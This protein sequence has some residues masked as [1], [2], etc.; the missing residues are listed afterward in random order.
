MLRSVIIFAFKFCG[1]PWGLD[2]SAKF[3]NLLLQIKLSTF[4]VF[5][6]NT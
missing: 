2:K 3:S 1:M 4:R 6:M 5:G